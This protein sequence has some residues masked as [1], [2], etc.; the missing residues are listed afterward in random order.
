MMQRRKARYTLA[1][2]LIA[3]LTLSATIAQAG[4]LKIDPQHSGVNFRVTHLMFMKVDGKFREFEGTFDFDDDANTISNIEVTIQAASVD[5]NVEA[6]DK[7]L[8]SKRFFN[9]EKYPTLT[10]K[11]TV[12]TKLNDKKGQ[13]KGILTMHGV[14]KEVVL[15][16][17]LLGKGKDPWGNLKYGFQ[18][19]TT[20][21]RKDFG[22]MW[23]EALE[24]GG[25]MVGDE[26][27]VR[28]NIEAAPATGV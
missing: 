21:N 10:F 19:T 14:E 25:V 9:V 13:I 22:M 5:T 8:R 15:D 3:G 20:L 7:D 11:S 1:A 6:R 17:E 27:E 4:S 16:A 12:P 23:N 2:V 24:A 26:V 28:L 18:A